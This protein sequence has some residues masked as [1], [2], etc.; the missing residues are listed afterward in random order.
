MTK[1][2]T[3]TR[4]PL[5]KQEHGPDYAVPYAIT[6]FE[7]LTDNSW[8]NDACPKFDVP[9]TNDPYCELLITLW[10]EHPDPEQRESGSESSRFIVAID[11]WDTDTAT[12]L[13]DKG[14]AISSYGENS[15]ETDDA[16]KAV[17]TVL[18]TLIEVREAIR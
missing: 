13:H 9:V 10:V 11:A 18:D 6:Q 7:G 17:S 3:T 2:Q 14:F 5:W 1:T 12:K 16:D 15:Y 4:P 8:H